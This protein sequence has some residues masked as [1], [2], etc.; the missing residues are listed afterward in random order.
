MVLV[1][2]GGAYGGYMADITRT[3][4]IDG[5]FTS[6]QRDLY[7]VVLDTQRHC[8]ALCRQNADTSLDKLHE[9]ATTGLSDGLQRLGF[10]VS[11]QVRWP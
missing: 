10:D 6:A 1:D 8:I 7:Q 11:G 2:A 9:I 5:T 3:W 4:P